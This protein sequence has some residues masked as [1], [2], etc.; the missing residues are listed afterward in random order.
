MQQSK[1]Q[2]HQGLLAATSP[3]TVQPNRAGRKTDVIK[4]S[5]G[6]KRSVEQEETHKKIVPLE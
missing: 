1:D 3:G 2:K 4:C 6:R 5:R